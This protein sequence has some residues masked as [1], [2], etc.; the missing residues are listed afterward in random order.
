MKHQQCS[1]HLEF[2][3][4]VD[5]YNMRIYAVKF[6]STANV[7]L[8]VGVCVGILLLTILGEVVVSVVLAGYFHRVANKRQP[9]AGSVTQLFPNKLE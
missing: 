3:A 9:T 5:S 7:G 2:V 8:T 1:F 4:V 6:T